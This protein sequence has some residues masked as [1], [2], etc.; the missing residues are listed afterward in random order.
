MTEH[1]KIS[2]SASSRWLKCPA[3][4][5][6]CAEVPQPAV[7][8]VYGDIGTLAHHMAEVGLVHQLDP[9]K[10]LAGMQEY[11]REYLSYIHMLKN[12]NSKMYIEVR[13]KIFKSCFG[14]ADC[15]LY[16]PKKKHLDIVDLKYGKSKVVAE[17]N[18]QLMLY[19]FGAMKMI[20]DKVK[21]ISVHIG[22]PRA[23]NFDRWDISPKEVKKFAKKAKKV[24]LEGLTN[25]KLKP[26]YDPKGC[27]WCEAKDTC[28]E[29]QLKS[30][31]FY[32]QRNK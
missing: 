22:Q 4:I 32:G 16:D 11:V 30:S 3:S 20:N 25:D 17:N 6:M 9:V 7:N 21:T 1:A 13:L 31:P 18:T 15:V 14:T 28:E 23:N 8:N 19:A 29:Y 27:Y 26:V 24:G 5:R 2:P 12:E 10:A